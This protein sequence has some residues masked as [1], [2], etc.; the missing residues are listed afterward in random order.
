MHQEMWNNNFPFFFCP[1]Y[2]YLYFSTMIRRYRCIVDFPMHF[3]FS[4]LLVVLSLQLWVHFYHRKRH[5]DIFNRK[6]LFYTQKK[7]KKIESIFYW[8]LKGPFIEW[9]KLTFSDF[10]QP[11]IYF[12]IFFYPH[13]FQKIT[14]NITQ[15]HLPNGP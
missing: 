1:F 14:N 11:Y 5:S 9:F 4:S 10:K 13:V 15:N 12:H 3:V 8:H 2:S 6:L 7:K